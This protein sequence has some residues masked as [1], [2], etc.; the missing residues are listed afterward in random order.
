VVVARCGWAGTPDF[1]LSGRTGLVN[2]LKMARTALPAEP[3]FATQPRMIRG[4][5]VAGQHPDVEIVAEAADGKPDA[6]LVDVEM[7]GLSGVDMVGQIE[8]A[9]RP[10][11]P[12]ISRRGIGSRLRRD[13]IISIAALA[14]TQHAPAAPRPLGARAGGQGVSVRSIR[15]VV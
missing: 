12:L 2:F 3:E 8:A 11:I 13:F 6:V 7:A 10:A 1:L 14:P 9:N 5:L 15:D 4:L